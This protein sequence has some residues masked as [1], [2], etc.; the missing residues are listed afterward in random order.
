MII[1]EAL[2]TALTDVITKGS[3]N[4]DIINSL[5]YE[6]SAEDWP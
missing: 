5:V 1:I 6:V 3:G 2:R 4:T